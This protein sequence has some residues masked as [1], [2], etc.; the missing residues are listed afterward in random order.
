MKSVIY[1]LDTD[2]ELSESPE[3]FVPGPNT[4]ARTVA[5]VDR[6]TNLRYFLIIL[7]RPS[8]IGAGTVCHEA[9][10]A[11][12]MCAEILGFLPEKSQDDEPCAYLIQWMSNCI[13]MV[14][15][16]HPE[17]MKGVIWSPGA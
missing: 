1:A 6:V 15:K 8:Q 9:Y 5:V 13:D 16:G 12:N 17:R 3:E 10:H 14:L 11:M 4:I 2:L 7:C